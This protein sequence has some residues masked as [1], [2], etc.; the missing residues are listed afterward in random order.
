MEAIKKQFPKYKILLTFFSPS[1]Y[2]IRKN[3][4]GADFVCYL[5]LDTPQNA[6]RF[7]ELIRPQM[8]VFVKYE[9]WKNFLNQLHKNEVPVYLISAIFKK[10]QL[11]FKFYGKFYRKLLQYFKHI[12]VQDHLSEK[13]LNQIGVKNV[14]V[15]GDTRFDR[16]FEI[17]QNAKEIP[18]A[19]TFAKNN[20]VFIVGSSWQP[21]EAIIFEYFNAIAQKIKYIIAP[22]EVHTENIERIVKSISGKVIRY[23]QAQEKNVAENDVLIID[24]IGMLSSLYQYG[25]IAYIGGGFGAGIHNVLEAATFGMPTIFGQNYKQFKEAGDLVQIQAAFPISDVFEFKE[26]IENLINNS[27][28]RKQTA[29]KAKQFVAENRGATEKIL[30]HLKLT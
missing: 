5:P 3:Y 27:D 16:V 8:V 20:L 23:S 10:N 19:K 24:N 22:H 29:L 4:T 13:L 9:F 2:E 6:K 1:G 14:T 17:A 26:I 7:V 21:D 25:H 11:F 30:G 28:F 15:A 18:I 12:F